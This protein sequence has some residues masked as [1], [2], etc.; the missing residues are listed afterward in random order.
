MILCEPKKTTVRANLILLASMSQ[1]ESKQ[2]VEH[3]R[4]FLSDKTDWAQ[5]PAILQMIMEESWPLLL[6]HNENEENIWKEF[7]EL[8]VQHQSLLPCGIHV[9]DKVMASNS[10][11]RHIHQ[12]DIICNITSK[13]QILNSLRDYVKLLQQQTHDMDKLSL[14][15]F[16]EMSF[17]CRS[18]MGNKQDSFAD[19]EAHVVL[20][21]FIL[22]QKKQSDAVKVVSLKKVCLFNIKTTTVFLDLV[23]SV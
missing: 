5:A 9:E 17:H 7:R 20:M 18:G 19:K 12:N 2:F 8:L 3:A 1:I 10:L 11:L 15:L 4:K 22:F 23:C 13:A 16:R 6:A 14:F 21:V